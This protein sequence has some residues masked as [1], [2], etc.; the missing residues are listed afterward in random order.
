MHSIRAYFPLL[1]FLFLL[2]S[3]HGQPFT[4]FKIKH[5]AQAA[6]GQVLAIAAD[7]DGSR[8]N[9]IFSW[10]PTG[11]WEPLDW[12]LPVNLDEFQPSCL[13]P[14][15]KGGIFS[16]WERIGER[17]ALAILYHQGERHELVTKLSFETSQHMPRTP[18]QAVEDGFGALWLVNDTPVALQVLIDKKQVTER[19]LDLNYFTGARLTDIRITAG[20][21]QITPLSVVRDLRG[22]VWFLGPG[23]SGWGN[24][25][26]GLLLFDG[27]KFIHQA[28]VR[29]ISR[30]WPTKQVWQ[31][32][33]K[34][35]NTLYAVVRGVGVFE[36]D[37]ASLEATALNEPEVKAFASAQQVFQGAR[38]LWVAAISGGRFVEDG[39]T[40]ESGTHPT[41]KLWRRTGASWDAPLTVS[42]K[43]GV[44]ASF[45][46]QSEGTWIGTAG[47][48]AWFVTH[49][50]HAL[51]L[52]WRRCNPLPTV[53]WI[54][55]LDGSR[56]LLVGRER[57]SI[58]NNGVPTFCDSALPEERVTFRS[59]IP[60]GDVQVDSTRGVWFMTKDK[61]R[62][63]RFWDGKDFTDY[64]LPPKASADFGEYAIRSDSAGRIWFIPR[65]RG[66]VHLFT[67]AAQA[68][69]SFSSFREALQAE[70]LAASGKLDLRQNV[71][72]EMSS[73]SL[74]TYAPIVAADGRIAYFDGEGM[75]R[76]HYFD[77]KNW[78]DWLRTR[79]SGST[80][81][82]DLA[83]VLPEQKQQLVLMQ[84]KQRQ[85]FTVDA[86]ENWQPLHCAETVAKAAVEKPKYDREFYCDSVR[87]SDGV[88]DDEMRWWAN[89]PSGLLV[90]LGDLCSARF[91]I[92]TP[93]PFID[94]RT[95]RAVFSDRLANQIFRSDSGEYVIA[96]DG[97]IAPRLDLT[98][99]KKTEADSIDVIFAGSGEEPLKYQWRL[100]G[101]EWSAWSPEK[102]RPFSFLKPGMHVIEA[103]VLD[104]ALRVGGAGA[105]LEINVPERGVSV[106]EQQQRLVKMLLA[107]SEH[108]RSQALG[109]VKEFPG[110]R[111]LLLDSRETADRRG[112]W[113]IEL[114]LQELADK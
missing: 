15:K 31:L 68:W 109:K 46:E 7:Q 70:A 73:D 50:G 48:A 62:T 81:P 28:A 94:G 19:A 32:A 52:D 38:S 78:H 69:R 114:A 110:I 107:G 87:Q 12:R 1:L 84:L 34:D 66:A 64:T 51:H 96:L 98:A 20:A 27:K 47:D 95:I 41:I 102:R 89:T 86:S 30:F 35:E 100:D 74:N 76:L 55:P 16:V 11:A 44:R 65:Y 6:D 3:A 83:L 8:R 9:E 105:K 37:A 45:L 80:R 33:P 75:G 92:H 59:F 57:G 104:R 82:Y 2:K 67:P 40:Y 36:I 13:V 90:A 39:Y 106:E 71:K 60:D 42:T 14:S 103:R 108:E 101:G 54:F 112:R 79:P 4:A 10:A 23:E 43:P 111:Q 77:G 18:D 29:G 72:G 88:R 56:L 113:W 25:L 58:V 22:R 61:E 49:G 63:V 24:M 26:K 53:D 85:C 5:A 99:E 21:P 93:N 91:S 97:A 17:Y